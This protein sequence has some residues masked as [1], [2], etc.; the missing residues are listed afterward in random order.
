SQPGQSQPNQTAPTQPTTQ[1]SQAP[2]AQPPTL[3]ILPIA[4][5]ILIVAVAMLVL[6]ALRE[7]K[8]NP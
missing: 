5:G 1:P 6:L 7:R 3:P 4:G 8:K 2:P